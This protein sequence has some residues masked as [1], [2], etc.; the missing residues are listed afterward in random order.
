MHSLE[1]FVSTISTHVKL[2]LSLVLTTTNPR[3]LFLTFAFVCLNPD[4]ALLGR[5][6]SSPQSAI[7]EKK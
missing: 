1:T 7:L 5:N 2:R 3:H 4:Q 6:N